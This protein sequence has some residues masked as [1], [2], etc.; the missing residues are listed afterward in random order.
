MK[1]NAQK[2]SFGDG[3]IA[4]EN[5]LTSELFEDISAVV[6]S[7]LEELKKHS[8]SEWSQGDMQ[9][10]KNEEYRKQNIR[11]IP[12]P[13]TATQEDLFS[14]YRHHS[15]HD[16]D[17]EEAAYNRAAQND[18]ERMRERVCKMYEDYVERVQ[19]E[20]EAAAKREKAK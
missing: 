16:S 7:S 18:L 5:R 3:T 4:T 9:L 14:N 19:A 12:D 11:V 2:E 8:Q 6:A 20:M 17:N 13:N 10:Y 1:F 15:N